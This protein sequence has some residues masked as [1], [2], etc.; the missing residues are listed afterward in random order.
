MKNK[1]NYNY[2]LADLT[3]L[4]GVGKKTMQIFKKKKLIISLIYYGGCPSLIQTEHW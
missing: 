1:N 4:N 3:K 2:L